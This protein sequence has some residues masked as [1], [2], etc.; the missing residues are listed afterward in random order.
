M[1]TL[2]RKHL[3][4]GVE[5]LRRG[6]GFGLGE[7]ESFSPFVF[8]SFSESESK[9]FQSPPPPGKQVLPKEVPSVPLFQFGDLIGLD[10]L[11]ISDAPTSAPREP[12]SENGAAVLPRL[13]VGSV[14][15]L[16][17][18]PIDGAAVQRSEEIPAAETISFEEEEDANQPSKLGRD[19][20]G[21]ARAQAGNDQQ[22]SAK[23]APKSWASLVGVQQVPGGVSRSPGQVKSAPVPTS[24]PVTIS[25]PR[26][27]PRGLINTG[28]SCFA[29]ATLQALLS[30]PPFL[31]LLASIKS[32][33]IPQVSSTCRA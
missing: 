25:S 28:N 8:G 30:C 23:Q 5:V 6:L 1:V 31:N 14:E 19:E 26:I 17:R 24:K 10:D 3:R 16:E 9:Y 7:Q 4:I 33:T 22:A 2:V 21:Q 32:R 11:R 29:N 27:Q 15:V 12:S 18:T 20:Q 13:Q